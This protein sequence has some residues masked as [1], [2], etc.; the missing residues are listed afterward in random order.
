[1][2]EL[3]KLTDHIDKNNYKCEF[4]KNLLN[5]MKDKIIQKLQSIVSPIKPVCH[6]TIICKVFN[7]TDT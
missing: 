7:E 4:I 5:E 1:M 6:L 2:D 3:I